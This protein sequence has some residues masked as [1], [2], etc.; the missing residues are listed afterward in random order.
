M[1][2]RIRINKNIKTNIETYKVNVKNSSAKYAG[3]SM[4][5]NGSIDVLII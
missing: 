3:L 2:G 5:V 4:A 1:L